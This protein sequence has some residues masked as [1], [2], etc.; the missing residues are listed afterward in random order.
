[1]H[2]SPSLALSWAPIPNSCAMAGGC[3]SFDLR[4]WGVSGEGG[5]DGGS[6][7][8]RPGE[9]AEGGRRVRGSM[10]NRVEVKGP[11]WMAEAGMM[12]MGVA[13]QKSGGMTRG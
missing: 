4:R 10:W 7:C 6:C 9:P 13:S 3:C 1:M 11:G 2:G 5:G 8:S 12:W